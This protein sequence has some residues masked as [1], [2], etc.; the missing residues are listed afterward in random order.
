MLRR[1]EH[2]AWRGMV[3]APGRGSSG[4]RAGKVTVTRA[5]LRPCFAARS[6]STSTREDTKP[7][8]VDGIST[9]VGGPSGARRSPFA[10]VEVVTTSCGHR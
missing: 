1:D 7:G 6:S 4:G 2:P 9:L 8:S 3:S 10:G 5:G